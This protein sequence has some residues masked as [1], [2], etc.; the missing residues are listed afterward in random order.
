MNGRNL[1][2]TLFPS[3]PPAHFPAPSVP[4][5]IEIK[6]REKVDLC[7]KFCG[8]VSLPLMAYD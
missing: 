7:T 1:R 4:P 3:I 2:T 6:R 5:S 8:G